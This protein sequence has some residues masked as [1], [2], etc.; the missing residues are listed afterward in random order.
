MPEPMTDPNDQRKYSNALRLQSEKRIEA[1]TQRLANGEIDLAAWQVNMK[2]ELRRANLEQFVTGRGGDRTGIKPGEYGTL[3]PELKRQYKYL[4]NF[5]GVIEAAGENGSPLD[6]AIVRAKLYAK[7]T[8]A[9]FWKSSIPVDLPQTPRDGKTRCRTNCKC[10]LQH[11]LEYNADGEA[12]AVLVWWKLSPAEHCEDCL[13]LARTWNPLRIEMTKG[14][15]ES[16]WKQAVDLLLIES[17]ELQHGHVAQELYAMWD[18]EEEVY[19]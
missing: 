11:K 19:A 16:S 18:I 17:P 14:V 5:A 3:G 9:S 7:S 4:R 13:S 2:D 10:R 1:L 15:S 12:I 6:F 8:Q